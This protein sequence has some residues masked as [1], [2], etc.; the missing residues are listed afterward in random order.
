MAENEEYKAVHYG[1]YI[2]AIFTSG[3]RDGISS[4]QIVRKEKPVHLNIRW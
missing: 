1:N 2:Q 3:G 4:N